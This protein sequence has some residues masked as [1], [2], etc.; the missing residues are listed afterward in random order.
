MNRTLFVLLPVLLAAGCGESHDHDHPHPHAPAE[1]A[2]TTGHP[3]VHGE[4]VPLGTC[5][6]GEFQLSVFQVAPIKP[7]AEA[8]F[9]VEVA[10]AKLPPVLRGW[11]GLESGIGSLKV[12]FENE[13]A[14]RMHGHP[15]VPATLPA[16]SAIWFET[17]LGTGLVRGSVPLPK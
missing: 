8:D 14:T 5:S 6:L 13:T 7:G 15:E 9:D 3:H 2:P 4:R 11:I 17:E 12:R 1:G 10:T 16:G